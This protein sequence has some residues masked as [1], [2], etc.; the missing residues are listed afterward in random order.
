MT[1]RKALMNVDKAE[2][3]GFI[4]VDH[5]ILDIRGIS[6]KVLVLNF[7]DFWQFWRFWQ[8]LLSA[9]FRV[10]P[11]FSALIRGKRFWLSVSSVKISVRVRFAFS[12]TRLPDY[13]IT[14]LPQLPNALEI[15]GEGKA[16]F[17]ITRLPDY[18]ISRL[19][20]AFTRLPN[21]PM[22]SPDYPITGPRGFGYQ[23]HQWR[24]VVRVRFAFQL[25]DFPITQ[26]PN[27]FTRLPAQEVLVI[28]VISGDQW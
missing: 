11:R 7:G 23:C 2:K 9:F 26:L 22:P 12:I 3:I 4:S 5:W 19:P 28:S 10:F 6:G 21:Y 14:R 17:S 18:P 13:P 20:N 8:T 27:A 25:P 1:L 16:C 24:S 15:S